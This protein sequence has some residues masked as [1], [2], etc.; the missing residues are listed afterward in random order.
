MTPNCP[1]CRELLTPRGDY[2]PRFCPRCGNRLD[3]PVVVSRAL[4]RD[5]RGT[6]ALAV[7]ALVLGILSLIIPFGCLPF[8][9][10]AIVLG[11]TALHRI[12]RS[13]NRLRGEG[14]ATAGMVLGVIGMILWLLI[15]VAR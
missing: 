9:T 1:I 12:R 2:P 3:D 11:A 13:S 7:T 5:E 10:P 6:S 4:P 8:G 15:A 14:L